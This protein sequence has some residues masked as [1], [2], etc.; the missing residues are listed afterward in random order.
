MAS[1]E[2]KEKESR[3]E[4]SCFICTYQNPDA[5]QKCSICDGDRRGAVSFDLLAYL[6]GLN[7][8]IL[9]VPGVGHCFYHTIVRSGLAPDVRHLRRM[10]A[11]YL[12]AFRAET[13]ETLIGKSFSEFIRGI[14][15]SAHA[16]NPE[17][18]AVS[19]L[20]G[21]EIFIH[22]TNRANVTHI[23]PKTNW[24]NDSPSVHILY[25]GCH[26][27]LLVPTEDAKERRRQN[28]EDAEIARRFQEAEDAKERRRQNAEDAEIA[29]RFQEAEDAKERRRQNAE[30]A[31]RRQ[32]AEIARRRQEAEDS[33]IARRFQDAE[34]AEIAREHQIRLDGIFARTIAGL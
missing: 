10:V 19:E 33:E 9:T 3:L 12:E 4:W 26:Y 17:I 28:A 2:H 11:G 1:T 31:R 23:H 13:E 20:L 8:C 24:S 5:L 30:I 6:I 7:L 27:D 18:C 21:I 16:D 29:R 32:E 14:R 25:N 15:E 34:D 22:L